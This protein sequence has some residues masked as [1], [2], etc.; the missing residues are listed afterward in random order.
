MSIVIRTWSSPTVALCMALSLACAGLQRGHT[1]VPASVQCDRR[2]V[3]VSNST[4]G[5][6]EI[7]A[8]LE[9]GGPFVGAVGPFQSAHFDIPPGFVAV[10]LQ[11]TNVPRSRQRDV[12]TRIVC[13]PPEP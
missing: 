7:Y 12:A 13:G 4:G 5:N 10:R 2:V 8:G 1:G 9:A 6:V 11:Y 3:E